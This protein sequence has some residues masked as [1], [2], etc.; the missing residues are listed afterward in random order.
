MK[1]YFSIYN[2]FRLAKL[3]KR[4]PE[5]QV[6]HNYLRRTCFDL[7]QFLSSSFSFLL[8]FLIWSFVGVLVLKIPQISFL[9]KSRFIYIVLD[10]FW[11]PNLACTSHIFTQNNFLL[12]TLFV[13]TLTPVY[14]S[15]AISTILYIYTKKYFF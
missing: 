9:T 5:I 11:T 14:F 1:F 8:Y 3:S 15:T 10:L 13:W 6:S 4:K 12:R 7:S 2:G